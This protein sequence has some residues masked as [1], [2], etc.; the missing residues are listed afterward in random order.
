MSS[1]IARPLRIT[2]ARRA[3]RSWRVGI[4]RP[5]A[6]RPISFALPNQLRDDQHVIA[7]AF[8]TKKIL[9]T[10]VLLIQRMNHHRDGLQLDVEILAVDPLQLR[11]SS[12]PYCSS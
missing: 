1:L 6:A 5:F 9:Q 8:G 4:S 3:G 7:D 11:N 12:M 2:R 10:G